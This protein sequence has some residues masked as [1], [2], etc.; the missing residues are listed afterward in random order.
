[1]NVILGLGLSCVLALLDEV[2]RRG[3]YGRFWLAKTYKA[4]NT[5]ILGR[6]ATKLGNTLPE[7]TAVDVAA[8]YLRAEK[9]YLWSLR[10]HNTPNPRPLT[11]LYCRTAILAGS[12]WSH[13]DCARHYP[14]ARTR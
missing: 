5:Q 6:L 3:A 2:G 12:A 1:M 10:E 4:R 11:C 7:P 8:E 13:K 14:I 9:A